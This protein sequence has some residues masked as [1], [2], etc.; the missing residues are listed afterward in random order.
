[1][2]TIVD[3][4]KKQNAM[5]QGEVERFAGAVDSLSAKLSDA[6]GLL[7]PHEPAY[8]AAMLGEDMPE[9]GAAEPAPGDRK[10]RRAAKSSKTGSAGQMI[11]DGG[12]T[13]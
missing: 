1:M 5:L 8:V 6:Y 7:R 3:S 2:S 10:Q 12:S 11:P 13:A 9:P 4:L